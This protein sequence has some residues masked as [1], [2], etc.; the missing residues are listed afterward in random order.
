MPRKKTEEDL[1]VDFIGDTIST[2]SALLA[3]SIN[4]MRAGDI[5]KQMQDTESLLKVSKAWYELARFLGGEEEED[6]H[7]PIGFT[8]LE[9]VDE[10]GDDSDESEGGIEVRTKSGK[11]RKSS[12]RS[13]RR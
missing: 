7:N 10:P 2:E 3:C 11:L 6:K 13:R 8:V 9:T 4:L 12:S 1:L 5:A